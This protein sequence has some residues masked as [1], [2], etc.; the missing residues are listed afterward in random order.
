MSDALISFH[1]DLSDD[2]L[3]ARLSSGT[4]TEEAQRIALDECRSRG[5]PVSTSKELPAPA[6]SA[7]GGL[8]AFVA[9]LDWTDAQILKGLLESEGIPVLI[10]DGH[11]ATANRFLSVATGGVRLW[12][13]E[14]HVARAKEIVKLLKE[15]A[16]QIDENTDVGPLE[17]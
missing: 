4:L 14:E 15:G 3:L 10:A 11:L 17:S 5:L 13:H 2:A 7:A 12:L 8:R 9:H 6:D 16:F 1:R